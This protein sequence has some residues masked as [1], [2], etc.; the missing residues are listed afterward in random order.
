MIFNKQYPK[1]EYEA[2]KAAF[3]LD[4][5]EGVKR[6][7]QQTEDFFKTQ[8]HRDVFE[9]Q[10]Q[11]CIGDHLYNSKNSSYCFDCKDLEDC[12][13]CVR[14]F[15]GIKDCM[16]YSSWGDKAELIYH[17]VS[18]GDNAFNL[19]FCI[20]CFGNV[21]NLEYC[22][23]VVRSSDCF[24]CVGLKRKKF[25]IFN[26]Q[27]SEEEYYV[28]KDKII[29]HMKITG[30]YGK[31]HPK[32][33]CAHGYNVTLAMD[34]FPLSKEEATAEGY[35]WSESVVGEGGGDLV[36]ECGKSFKLIPQEMAFY[37]RLGIP[38]PE[39]CQ[40]CRHK[41]RQ[42]N[43]NPVELWERDCGRCG[44]KMMSSVGTD[45]PEIVYCKQCYLAEVY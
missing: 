33:F 7:R 38:R 40:L 4:T 30:E 26:K 24:G 41:A 25:C 45:R 29:E 43:R 2:H 18:C 10:N 1:E 37:E 19:K 13:Y 27:Y 39:K 20:H 12:K 28:L 14:L 32:G 31:F 16:D 36:C 3:E 5:N 8:V 22:Y 34:E 35:K 21:T 42:K 23:H 6:L 15:G 9:E 11:N 17:S 44:E